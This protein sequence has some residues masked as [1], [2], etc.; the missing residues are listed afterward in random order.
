MTRSGGG[1]GQ[2][3][4]IKLHGDP[5]DDRSER[6]NEDSSTA[7]TDDPLRSIRRIDQLTSPVHNPLGVCFCFNLVFLGLGG[8]LVALLMLGEKGTYVYALIV[9]SF[10][11]WATVNVMLVEIWKRSQML[12]VL[13]QEKK[14]E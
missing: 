2:E 9:S 11:L 8:S 5:D 4:E 7:A 14:N 12:D 6:R 13:Q 1:K 3:E 10:L